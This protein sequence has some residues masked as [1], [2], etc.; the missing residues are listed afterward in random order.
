MTKATRTLRKIK[1]QTSLSSSE[2]L[3]RR[4]SGREVSAPASGD[5]LIDLWAPFGD[6]F[7]IIPTVRAPLAEAH[8]GFA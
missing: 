4:V 2:T 8:A 7:F 3:D 6:V 1:D 5:D